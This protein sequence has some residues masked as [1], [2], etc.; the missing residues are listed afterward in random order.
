M[1]LKEIGS[2]MEGILLAAG[3][4]VGVERLC[5]TLGIDG[6]AADAVAIQYGLFIFC[7]GNRC[8]CCL[9]RGCR[10]LYCYVLRHNR[11][12][13]GCCGLG[14]SRRHLCCLRLNCCRLCPAH[15]VRLVCLSV[16]IRS[17]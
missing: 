11:R 5:L 10:C 16:R 13:L 4:P 9:C 12:C 8:Y 7:G 1:E 6:A 2:A 15:C 17:L 14:C 3:E